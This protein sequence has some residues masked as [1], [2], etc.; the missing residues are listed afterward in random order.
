[1]HEKN[2]KKFSIVIMNYNNFELIFDA[3]DSVCN[4]TY[5]NIE[6]VICDDAS[7]YFDQEKIIKYIDERNKN[8]D[9]KI[10]INKNNLGTV[11]AINKALQKTT[12]DYYLITASDDVLANNKVISNFVKYFEVTTS[13]VI[14]S[15]WITCDNELNKIND[16]IPNSKFNLYNKNQKKLLFDMCKCNRF[17][18][19]STA[20]K[21]EIFGKYTFDEK[22]KYLED[23]PFWLKLLFNNEKIYFAHFDGLLHRSGGISEAKVIKESTKQFYKELLETVHNEIIPNFDQFTNYQKWSILDSYK[24]NIEYYARYFNT[25]KYRKELK[26]I[27]NNNKIIKGYYIFNEI[28]PHLIRK[29]E[30]LYKFNR[31]I[32]RTFILTLI[33]SFLLTG[34]IENKNLKLLFII[35]TYIIVYVG[36]ILVREVRS[37]KKWKNIQ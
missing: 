28:N 32:P 37:R 3:I 36:L 20:Y 17:G 18:S 21:K 4:Q 7:K 14:T 10:V 29:I 13:S 34:Y 9:I 15:Q 23:W 6:L 16:Y 31:I 19:G 1:M 24:F 5:K 30:I 12:G 33:I 27:V 11:K 35:I 22:Y 2:N 25:T 26:K 8:I